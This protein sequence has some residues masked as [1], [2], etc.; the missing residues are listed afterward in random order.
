MKIVVSPYSRAMRNG[1]KNPKNFPHWK[2]LIKELIRLG[3]EVV[4]IGAKGEDKIIGNCL[5]GAPLV[6]VK[7]LISKS[8]LWISVDNFLP[9]LANHTTTKGI[10]LFGKSDPNIYG[11]PQNINLLKDRKFLREKQFDIWEVEIYESDA[12]VTVDEVLSAVRQI[13]ESN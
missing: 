6:D 3:H 2:P 13:E 9:H 4:Q 5:F 10:V 1:A 7:K 11:Y 12:F 8:D